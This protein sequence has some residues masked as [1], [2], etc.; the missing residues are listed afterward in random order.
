MTLIV[1]NYTDIEN[2]NFI[3]AGFVPEDSGTP[4]FVDGDSLTRVASITII[5]KFWFFHAEA[6]A[7]LCYR[8]LI[9]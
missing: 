3:P 5:L 6:N 1:I 2:K 4:I 8:L 7:K 9:S